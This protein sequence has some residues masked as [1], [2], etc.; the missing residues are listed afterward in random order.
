MENYRISTT[1]KYRKRIRDI[2]RVCRK[3][4]KELENHPSI[5]GRF[6]VN[7]HHF[8][9]G[10]GKEVDRHCLNPYMPLYCHIRFYDTVDNEEIILCAPDNTWKYNDNYAFYESLEVFLL[11]IVRQHVDDFPMSHEEV[12]DIFTTLQRAYDGT[13]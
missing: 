10:R 9:Y 8:E 5:R 2:A 4:N 1:D 7:L 11:K 3:I 12:D 13:V 6:T